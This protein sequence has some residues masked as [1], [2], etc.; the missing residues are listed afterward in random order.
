MVW[1]RKVG[2]SGGRC[3]GDRL[4][5]WSSRRRGWGWCGMRASGEGTNRGDGDERGGK[6]KMS[7]MRHWFWVSVLAIAGSVV[8][9]H[10]KDDTAARTSPSAQTP[11]TES[12]VSKP[13][14]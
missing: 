10:G 6:R 12:N 5:R 2:Q 14:P 3:G 11:Q 7:Q 8:G 9:C 1:T 13:A 4:H